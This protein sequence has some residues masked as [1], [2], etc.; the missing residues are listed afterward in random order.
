M[1]GTIA[2]R[3]CESQCCLHGNGGRDLACHPKRKEQIN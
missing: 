3:T 1:S 2:R